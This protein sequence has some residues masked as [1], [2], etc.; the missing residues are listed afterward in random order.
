MIGIVGLIGIYFTV[1]ATRDLWPFTAAV[2]TDTPALTSETAAADTP[3]APTKPKG[4]AMATRE[5]LPWR[6]IGSHNV[7]DPDGKRWEKFQPEKSVPG[8]YLSHGNTYS[9]ITPPIRISNLQILVS[10]L[11]RSTNWTIGFY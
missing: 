3:V 6:R 11:L 9:G 8:I 1:A 5:V 2:T 4:S 7:F 10:Q